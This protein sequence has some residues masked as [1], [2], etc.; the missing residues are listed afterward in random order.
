MVAA[1]GVG[2]LVLAFYGFAFGATRLLLRGS[3]WE[4]YSLEAPCLTG[5]ALVVLALSALGYRVPGEVLAWQAWA[6]LAV[7]A[8]LSVAVA[9]WDRR[10]LGV[11]LRER[12]PR[13][14]A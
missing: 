12:W 7:G 11:L 3:A 2:L 6:L 9:V 14:L 13:L 10:A 5:P 8:A 1:L 4:S